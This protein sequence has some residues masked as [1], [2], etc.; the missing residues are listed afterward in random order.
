VEALH[1]I[2][3]KKDER[4]ADIPNYQIILLEVLVASGE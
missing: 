4:A 1:K 3:R 2:E